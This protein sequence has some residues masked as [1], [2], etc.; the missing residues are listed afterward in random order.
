[1]ECLYYSRAEAVNAGS[2]SGSAL[3][4]DPPSE[5]YI[6]K[7]LIRFLRSFS[8]DQKGKGNGELGRAEPNHKY[9]SQIYNILSDMDSNHG[10]IRLN[11]DD[12]NNVIRR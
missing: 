6:V 9:D 5:S 8:S 10:W 4:L 1:M 3:P 12:I 7:D 11:R 2:L